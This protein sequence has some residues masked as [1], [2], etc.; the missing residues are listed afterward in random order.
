LFSLVYA[1]DAAIAF[2]S[3]QSIFDRGANPI[4][5][6]FAAEISQVAFMKT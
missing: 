5:E 6:L 1:L 3:F 4:R 2:T